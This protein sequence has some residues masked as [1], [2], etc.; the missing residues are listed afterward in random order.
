MTDAGLPTDDATAKAQWEQELEN[1]QITVDNNSPFSPFWRTVEALITMP[2][3]AL[4]KWMAEKLMPDMF[5]M[6]ASRDALVT[7]HGPSRN[8]FV[9]DSIKAKGF[10]IINREDATGTLT[11]NAG[12]VI[13]SDS[14][15]GVVYQ[16]NALNTA[17]FNAG[18]TQT[19]IIVE[20]TGTGQAYNLPSGSYYNL[21]E[22]IDG[23]TITNDDD[24]LITPGADEE[25][26]ESYRDRIRNVFG[27]AAKWHINTVYK[28]IISDFGIPIDNIEIINGAPRGAGTADAYIYLTI[29]T[30]STAL[31]NAINNHVRVDGHHGHG[32]DFMVYAMPTNNYDLVAF[33]QLHD[34]SNDIGD[35]LNNFIR[36]AFRQ[37]DVWQPTRTSHNSIFSI[38]LLKTEMHNQFP[39][40]KTIN[41]NVDDIESQLWLPQL[42]SL[43]MQN[44]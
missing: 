16:V 1:Q 35:D 28:S 33:Y 39:E 37:N 18:E 4:L 22:G 9:Y 14:I 21:V 13:E 20:A 17:V 6:T 25:D 3:V 12:S 43:V 40:L 11:I 34:N 30:V 24:W 29:G 8:V 38:S 41:F 23:V 36:A 44:G 31:I 32:D 27:T 5:I 42:N 10:L 7:L 15:G 19:Q 26:T 2:V